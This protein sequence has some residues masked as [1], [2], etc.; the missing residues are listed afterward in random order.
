MGINVR[1]LDSVNA[2]EVDPGIVLAWRDGVDITL[3]QLIRER[4][5]LDFEK[6]MA[7]RDASLPPGHPLV[8]PAASGDA[9]ETR[10]RAA[11]DTAIAHFQRGAFF[12]AVDGRQVEALD[13]PFP[14]RPTSTVKF[15]RLIQ[16][17]GG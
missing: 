11:Q 12:V 9:L 4:V 1:I 7:A 5:R 15:V 13:A 8:A 14:L 2:R 6:M 3:R 17:K 10:L 16:L